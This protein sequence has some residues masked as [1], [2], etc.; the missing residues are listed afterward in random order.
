MVKILNI[1]YVKADLKHVTDNTTQ[2]NVEERALFLSLI[3]DSKY[4]FDGTLVHLA[5]EPVNLELNIFQTV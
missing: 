2:L 4:L 1:N 3:E 5:A